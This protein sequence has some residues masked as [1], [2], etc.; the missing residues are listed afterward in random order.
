MTDSKFTTKAA[1]VIAAQLYVA[2]GF[3]SNPAM[4]IKFIKTNREYFPDVSDQMLVGLRDERGL[5][6]AEID[7]QENT[8]F[9]DINTEQK[10][11][12]ALKEKAQELDKLRKT[13]KRDHR[14][15]GESTMYTSP[16]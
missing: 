6:D 10:F 4:I 2:K 1:R 11:E 13:E 5:T 9:A 14:G 7:R 8:E 12:K 16:E 3:N 15:R